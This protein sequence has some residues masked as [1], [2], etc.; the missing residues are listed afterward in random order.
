MEMLYYK[1]DHVLFDKRRSA[2]LR[3]VVGLIAFPATKATAA[4]IQG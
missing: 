2:I 4:G 1:Y 3:Q